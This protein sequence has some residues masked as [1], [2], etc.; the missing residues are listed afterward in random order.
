MVYLT[1]VGGNHGVLSLVF[2]KILTIDQNEYIN[3]ETGFSQVWI[4][5]PTIIPEKLITKQDSHFMEICS[6]R[7]H[8]LLKEF[9]FLNR[10]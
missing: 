7:L 2:Y 8:E 4:K 5:S 10:D 6:Y 3:N 9:D 1:L